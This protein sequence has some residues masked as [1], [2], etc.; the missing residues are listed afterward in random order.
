MA[1]IN[2]Y[3]KTEFGR[4]IDVLIHQTHYEHEIEL[5]G[6]EFKTQA[7]NDTLLQY[8]QSKNIRTN[9]TMLN[10]NIGITKDRPKNMS[11]ETVLFD[12]S[13]GPWCLFQWIKDDLNPLSRL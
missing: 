9:A 4:T 13:L 11:H 10:D 5:C 7:A 3:D 1:I 6:I 2:E 8:Q 12:L